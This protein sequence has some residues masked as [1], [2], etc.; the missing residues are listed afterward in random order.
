MSL[1][2]PEFRTSRVEVKTFKEVAYC[3]RCEGDN[4]GELEFQTHAAV[5]TSYPAQYSHVCNKCHWSTY[6]SGVTYP[7]YVY[8]GHPSHCD[9]K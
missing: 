5:L 1:A 2:R 4:P 6:L 7:R 3:P 8:E 9:A